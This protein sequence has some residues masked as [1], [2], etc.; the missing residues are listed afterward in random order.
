MRGRFRQRREGRRQGVPGDETG[1]REAHGCSGLAGDGTAEQQEELAVAFG[2]L[3]RRRLHP[4]PLQSYLKRR[5]RDVI[6]DARVHRRIA[7]DAAGADV[8]A[9]CLE[10]RLDERDHAPARREQRR[11]D[12]QDVGERDERDVDRDER[13]FT[14]ALRQLLRIADDARSRLRGTS[15]AGRS[16]RRQSSWL[17]PTSSATTRAAPRWSSTSVK[18]PVDA[19]MSRA[20]M[21]VTSRPNAS[22][23]CASFRPPRPTHG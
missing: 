16:C 22:S 13:E 10:L 7:H 18:P 5:A 17:W 20:V 15:R 1:A 8:L 2:A 4:D 12:G 14:Q 3:H 21:P 19:P 11:H 23:A 6:D 9:A